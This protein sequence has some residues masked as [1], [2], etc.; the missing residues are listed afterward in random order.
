VHED[1]FDG[2][3]G[4]VPK[5]YESFA[6]EWYDAE[7]WDPAKV[8]FAEAGGEVVGEI[9]WIHAEP[10]G[11]IPSLGVV[12][13]HRRQG[14][15]AALLARAFDAI[16]QAGHRRA[17]LSVDSENATGAVGVYERAG[18]HAYRAW[19]VYERPAP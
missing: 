13:A 12:P 3:F 17:T 16:A 14:I 18:M 7:D 10:D 11:Y 8:L 4:F 5:P 6:A 1:A 9:A 2:H 19:H 15:A